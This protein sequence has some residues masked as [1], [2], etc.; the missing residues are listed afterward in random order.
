MGAGTLH[1]GP[2]SA[3]A[4]NELTVTPLFNTESGL[5]ATQHAYQTLAYQVTG[6]ALAGDVSVSVSGTRSEDVTLLN[7]TL[8]SQKIQSA[9]GDT[10]RLAIKTHV[11]DAGNVT[12]EFSGGGTGTRV[13]EWTV[14][15]TTT[16]TPAQLRESGDEYTDYHLED[17]TITYAE[18][19]PS[20]A[21]YYAEANGE[22]IQIKDE[23]GLLAMLGRQFEAGEKIEDLV[24]YYTPGGM[25]SGY[26]IPAY[27]PGA[28]VEGTPVEPATVTLA[29]LQAGKSTYENRLVKVE[30]VVFFNK[31]GEG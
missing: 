21:S 1:A 27:D 9:E 15:P 30:K 20:G 12:L 31:A 5:V 19:S 4:D 7:A 16:V 17:M 14:Y 25:T 13:L 11:T 26:F 23:W 18:Y 8:S 28:A 29:E 24:G 10:L 2:G 22:G 3:K 6:Q